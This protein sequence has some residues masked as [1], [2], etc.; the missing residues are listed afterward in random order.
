ME[1][2]ETDA[3]SMIKTSILYYSVPNEDFP[4]LVRTTT[5]TNTA[6]YEVDLSILDGL[7]KLVPYG[8]SYGELNAMGRTMEA[9]MNVY[10]V[11]VGN[12]DLPYFHVS[13]KTGDVAQVTAVNEGHFVVAYLKEGDSTNLERLPFVLDPLKVFGSDSTMEIPYGFLGADSGRQLAEADQC[14]VGRTP[15]SFA[16]V[17]ATVA[18][19]ES[20][21]IYSLYGHS[22]D[23]EELKTVILPVIEAEDFFETKR[24]EARELA[25][26][27]TSKVESSTSSELFD[28]YV[29]MDYLDNLLRGGLPTV[30]GNDDSDNDGKAKKIFHTFSRIHGDMERDYNNFLIDMTYYSQGPG[31]FRD[32]NQNRRLDVSFDPRVGDFNVRTFLSLMQLDGYNPLTVPTAMFKIPTQD[33]INRVV[34]KVAYYAGAVN[35]SAPAKLESILAAPFRPGQ[36]FADMKTHNIVL[37]PSMSKAEFLNDVVDEAN[38][39]TVAMYAQNG[40]W[41]DHWTY[42]QDLLDDFL[43]IFPDKERWLLFHSDPLPSYISPSVVLPR[44]KRYTVAKENGRDFVRQYHSVADG[45]SCPHARTELLK[46]IWSNPHYVGDTQGGA[47]WHPEAKGKAVRLPIVSKLSMLGILKFA[48]LDPLGMGVEMEGGKPG[49]NDAMNGLP[50]LVGSGMPESYETLRLLT[51]LSETLKGYDGEHVPFPYEFSTMLFAV[52]SALHKYLNPANTRVE[53]KDEFLSLTHVPKEDFELWDAVNTAK[54]KYREGI[55]GKLS[56]YKK[57]W[58]PEDV[59]KSM[60]K[61]IIRLKEGQ[62]RALWLS[63]TGIAPTYFYFN[64]D[65]YYQKESKEQPVPYHTAFDTI[66]TSFEMPSILPLFLEGPVRQM[67]ILDSTEEKRQV[68]DDVLGSTLYDSKLGLYLI[69]ESLEGQPIT[70]GRMMAFPPGW[71]ENQSVWTHMSY[72]YYLELIRAGLYDE[73]FTAIKTGLV[74]FMNAKVD[75]FSPRAAAVL[76]AARDKATASRVLT[77]CV[78]LA[79]VRAISF[80]MLVL[81]RLLSFPGQ[82]VARNWIP[83]SLVWIHC[84]VPLDAQP[85]DG[86]APAIRG[87]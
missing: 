82:H 83:C 55:V 42:D 57:R 7:A 6:D 68:H 80:G 22:R 21:T 38:Q 20:I 50:G 84:G 87:R 71:L 32:V 79:G 13:Q 30:L 86:R 34:S 40:F 33:G 3:N 15:T 81:H 8:I 26:T 73:F 52:N 12:T 78:S 53:S 2:V 43:R 17:D 11:E 16:A 19:G 9:W 49:W 74:P 41:A 64:A 36:L 1:I 24:Q 70:I 63:Q 76:A 46:D 29:N 54:E 62:Q 45:D 66:V 31:N 67:K 58:T 10:N 18:P 28:K 25:D 72:K 23:V 61:M 69:S 77:C 75:F 4:G 59:S 85:H 44:A 60:Q 37:P 14:F 5:I 56:G 47:A 39:H 27:L 65:G 51:Y 35:E 48:T